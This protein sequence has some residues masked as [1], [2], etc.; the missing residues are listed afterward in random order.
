MNEDDNDDGDDNYNPPEEEDDGDDGTNLRGKTTTTMNLRKKTMTMVM[1]AF[2]CIALDGMACRSWVDCTVR[3]IRVL[4]C[5]LLY[6]FVLEVVSLGVVVF[7][8]A[9][10]CCAISFHRFSFSFSFGGL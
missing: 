8:R 6:A 10:M 7:E 1:M 9:C 3:Y 5:N 4:Y 2:Y